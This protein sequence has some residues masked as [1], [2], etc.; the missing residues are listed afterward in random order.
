M[1]PHHDHG[2]PYGMPGRHHSH[3]GMGD[4]PAPRQDCPPLLE[5]HRPHSSDARMSWTWCEQ[6]CGRDRDAGEIEGEE[7]KAKHAG[8]VVVLG[9]LDVHVSWVVEGLSG[10]KG[11]QLRHGLLL[12]AG[13]ICGPHPPN[14]APDPVS[15]G[16]LRCVCAGKDNRRCIVCRDGTNSG[17]MVLLPGVAAHLMA[18]GR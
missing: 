9:L 18:V 15:R 16:M 2:E 1:M 3:D 11:L 4:V 6:G 10:Q 14:T 17:P 13:S 5:N 12:P 7:R 8:H